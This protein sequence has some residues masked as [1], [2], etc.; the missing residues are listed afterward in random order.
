MRRTQLIAGIVV[1][2]VV[3]IAGGLTAYAYF[4]LS[5]IVAHNEK[6]ILAR[7]SDALGRRVEVGKIQAQMGW[8]G[9]N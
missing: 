9:S 4:N 5:S 3:L 6:R 8:G 7:V 2:A 1:G